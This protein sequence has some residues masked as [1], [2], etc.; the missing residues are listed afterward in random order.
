M[1]NIDFIYLTLQMQFSM[2]KPEF[3][4]QQQKQ[5]KS[6]YYYKLALLK[7]KNNIIYKYHIIEI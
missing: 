3:N 2:N 4:K 7:K 5:K 1:L 6:L